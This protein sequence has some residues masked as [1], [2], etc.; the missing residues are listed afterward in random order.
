MPL[1]RI[2]LCPIRRVPLR[3]YDLLLLRNDLDQLLYG[4]GQYRIYLEREL[5]RIAGFLRAI[6]ERLGIKGP[7]YITPPSPTIPII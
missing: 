3:H 2:P 1:R 7:D 5:C 6:L 4:L